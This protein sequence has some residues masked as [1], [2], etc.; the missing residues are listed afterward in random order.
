MELAQTI[1]LL[2]TVSLETARKMLKALQAHVLIL[3]KEKMTKLFSSEEKRITC[4]HYST[5]GLGDDYGKN[6]DDNGDIFQDVI[7]VFQ[8]GDTK[9]QVD[10]EYMKECDGR[11]NP[12]Y[13]TKFRLS[14]EEL[15]KDITAV[16]RSS[17][18]FP[19]MEA[20]CEEEEEEGVAT[21]YVAPELPESFKEKFYPFYPL[22]KDCVELIHRKRNE[23]NFHP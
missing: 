20:E 4:I 18:L 16:M 1:Q 15:T 14:H 22:V 7:F 2:N 17:Y 23:L 13:T 19:D 9:I 12:E 3:E 10:L 21:T 5:K 11:C 6:R 8:F